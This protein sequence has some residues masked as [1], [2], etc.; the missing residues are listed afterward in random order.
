MYNQI[1]QSIR[2][3]R[4]RYNLNDYKYNR[5]LIIAP[6]GQSYFDLCLKRLNSSKAIKKLSTRKDI[7]VIVVTSEEVATKKEF[8]NFEVLKIKE[9]NN[10]QS[11]ELYKSRFIKW[12]TPFLFN[13]IKTS[14]YIDS[15]LII[16]DD[17][18]KLLYVFDLTEKHGFLVTKHD[19][20]K[21]WLD[22]FNAILEYKYL[23][24]DKLEKQKILFQDLNI[25]ENCPVYQTNFLGRVHNTKYSALSWEVLNQLKEFSERDQ[26]AIIYAMY[27]CKIIPFSL[28]EG[29]ILYTGFV[30]HICDNTVTFV[31]PASLSVRRN[32]ARV[33][34][35]NKEAFI[36]LLIHAPIL[37]KE[38]IFCYMSVL[39]DLL[40][41]MP[42]L[43]L[44]KRF[45]TYLQNYF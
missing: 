44:I 7:K 34:G 27:K 20:R 15:D 19:I 2:T 40:F 43:N 32:E 21:G 14:L 41:E 36:F 31:D 5:A 11:G 25:P 6:F 38:N 33:A 1:E 37:I 4:D 26:L 35:R 10:W 24:R 8:K 39:K 30:N 16:T 29:E 45:F 9:I 13:N 22:E 17:I 23:D 18:L 12:G 42:Y 28:S 3:L